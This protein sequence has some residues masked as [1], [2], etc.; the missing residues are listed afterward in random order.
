[1]VTVTLLGTPACRR[2]QRMRDMVFTQAKKL[3]VS[4]ELKEIGDM[5]SLSKINPL[6]LPHLYVGNELIASQNP[7]NTQILEQ[8]LLS[9]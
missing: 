9:K 1:M 2:Y 4:I 8:A 7:P 6:S 3:E 5:E